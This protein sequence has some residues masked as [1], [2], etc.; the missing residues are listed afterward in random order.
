MPALYVA[1]AIRK[2][3]PAEVGTEI[4]RYLRYDIR[5]RIAIARDELPLGQ[6]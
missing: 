3:E 1:C 4:D 2:L 6:Y 5:N